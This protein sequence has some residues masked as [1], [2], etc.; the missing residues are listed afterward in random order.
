MEGR[1]NGGFSALRVWGAY[2]WRG[3]FSEFYGNLQTKFVVKCSALG[4][5][6]TAKTV[7]VINFNLCITCAIC[8]FQVFLIPQNRHCLT[9]C[10]NLFSFHWF[11]LLSLFHQWSPFPAWTFFNLCFFCMFKTLSFFTV[12]VLAFLLR[13]P[14]FSV[15][16]KF[17]KFT[18]SHP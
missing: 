15:F 14:S 16:V 11:C 1:F 9:D 17:F 6:V 3:L 18:N 2:K 4:P 12:S 10:K 13:F 8:A 5:K 7:F